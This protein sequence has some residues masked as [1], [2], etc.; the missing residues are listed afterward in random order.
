[1]G[2]SIVMA[3]DPTGIQDSEW[4]AVYEE[5]LALVDAYD[6]MDKYVEKGLYGSKEWIYVDRSRERELPFYDG[7]I[8]WTTF[9]DLKTMGYAEWFTLVRDMN[10]YR[11]GPS[12]N[13]RTASDSDIY[14]SRVGDTELFEKVRN[15]LPG[16]TTLIFDSKT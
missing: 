3:I 13:Q 5:S 10:F 9:G 1:M 12:V 8:G 16:K 14:L 4:K 6:F 15:K 2:I 11:K 7:T